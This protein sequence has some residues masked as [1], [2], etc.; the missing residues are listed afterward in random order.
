MGLGGQTDCLHPLDSGGFDTV[1]T[2]GS[3]GGIVGSRGGPSTGRV[4]HSGP[5]EGV[6]GECPPY[7]P[8]FPGVQLRMRVD[9]SVLISSYREVN[10]TSA[11]LPEAMHM[12]LDILA[13]LRCS[14]V[15]SASGRLWVKVWFA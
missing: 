7:V 13:D 5:H 10:Q 3:P 14:Q 2:G 9:L 12:I 1:V 6:L 15:I 4:F 8:R 11:S